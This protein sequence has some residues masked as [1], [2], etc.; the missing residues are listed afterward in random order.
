MFGWAI[1]LIL[2]LFKPDLMLSGVLAIFA[3]VAYSSL[4][5][6]AAFFEIGAACYLDGTRNRL[7]L[8]PL[9]VSGFLVSMVAISRAT[10]N[11]MLWD[12]FKGANSFKWDKTVRYRK[13]SKP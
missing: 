3:T 7:R 9:N 4:G 5:N 11:Q 8:L 12:R 10:F 2:Y 6:F 1:A 13:A